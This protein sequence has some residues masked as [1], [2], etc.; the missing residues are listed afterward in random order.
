M[1]HEDQLN[2]LEKKVRNERK[3]I[4]VMPVMNAIGGCDLDC[5]LLK[6]HYLGPSY[7]YRCGAGLGIQDSGECK[8]GPDCPAH[9]ADAGKKVGE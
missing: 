3:T 5:P 8:P 1:K 7:S 2:L 9:I 6:G 4:E